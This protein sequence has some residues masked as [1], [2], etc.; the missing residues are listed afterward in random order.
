MIVNGVR[1]DSPWVDSSGKCTFH[2][3]RLYLWYLVAHNVEVEFSVA[4][5]NPYV[6]FTSSNEPDPEK[7]ENS[8][9][10]TLGLQEGDGLG[11]PIWLVHSYR[12]LGMLVDVA[13][14]ICD[15]S[16]ECLHRLPSCEI[17]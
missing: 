2:V 13:P 8:R 14:S 17:H 7:I 4:S 15:H 16:V 9:V 1:I 3:A 6:H 10:M 5:P 11:T 12:C